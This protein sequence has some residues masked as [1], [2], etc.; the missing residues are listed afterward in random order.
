M[1]ESR[2]AG[3]LIPD[4][5]TRLRRIGHRAS[6]LLGERRLERSHALQPLLELVLL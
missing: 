2:R 1:A 3:T 5:V 6:S 4:R